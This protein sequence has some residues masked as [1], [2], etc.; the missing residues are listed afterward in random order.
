MDAKKYLGC[1]FV[2]L[3]D[4][5]E[6]PLRVTIDSIRE[7]KYGKLDVNFEEGYALSLNVTN[8][9]ALAKA[10]G[11][12]TDYWLSHVIELFSGEVEFQGAMQPTVL[13]RPISLAPAKAELDRNADMDD[14]VPF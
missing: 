4:V 14:D 1:S 12:E 11:A 7:G 2:T 8:T 5:A 13:V 6:G 10:Y 3:K 9:R